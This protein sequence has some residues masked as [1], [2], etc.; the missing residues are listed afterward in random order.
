MASLREIIC[1]TTATTLREYM[2]VET[3]TGGG[4][5][6]LIPYTE[7]NL[8]VVKKVMNIN[9]D[10]P[11]LS[12]AVQPK[13]INAIILTKKLSIDIDTSTKEIRHV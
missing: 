1:S 9:L 5:D 6:R 8:N 3:G 10:N 7:I 2:C 13:E 12:L 11:I 4:A